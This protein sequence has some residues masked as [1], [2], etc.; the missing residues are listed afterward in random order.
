MPAQK[1]EKDE[2]EE[3]TATAIVG[4]AWLSE[5]SPPA[6]NYP[7]DHQDPEDFTDT[8]WFLLLMK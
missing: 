2:N 3:P 8:H 1:K 7:E 4:S 6:E 5:V